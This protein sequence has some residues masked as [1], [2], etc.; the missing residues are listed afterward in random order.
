[1]NRSSTTH[2]LA[3]SVLA[4]SFLAGCSQTYK[5][6]SALPKTQIK[7]GSK[8]YTLE[9]A[10]DEPSR[11]H[12][13]MERDPIPQ[14]WGM[15]FVFPDEQ[16]RSFWMHHTRFALDILYVSASGKVVSIRTMKAYDENT[17]PSDGA[18]K[19][20]IELTAGQAKLSG[21]KEGDVLTIPPEAKETAQ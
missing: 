2:R 16:D 9:I 11:E 17:T 3:F 12:G 8:V 18:A 4:V 5:P 19:Y 20:A 1:M 13:L 10:A 6:P 7:I 21:V 14:D 15:I